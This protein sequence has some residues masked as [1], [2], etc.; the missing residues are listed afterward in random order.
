[1]KLVKQNPQRS[2][3][4]F[5]FDDVPTREFFHTPNMGKVIP[6]ANI[7]ENENGWR[8]EIAAP[9]F[10]KENIKVELKDQTLSISAEVKSET[11]E[12]RENYRRREFSTRSFQRNFVL[13]ETANTEAIEGQYTDGILT[14]KIPKREAELSKAAKQISLK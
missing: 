6:A 9:G 10:N 3:I 1:M 5:F 2:L 8:V 12:T 13:P 14:V 4:D 7:V 11:E